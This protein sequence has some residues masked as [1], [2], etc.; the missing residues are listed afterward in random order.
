MA[1]PLI[2]DTGG[3]LRA[4]TR[5]PDGRSAWPTFARAM[6]KAPRVVV[7][8]PV[9]TE[10]DYFL[11]DNRPAMRQLVA[12]LFNPA[13][14]LEYHHATP[15]D[16]LRAMQLDQKFHELEIGLV[17]GVVAAIAERLRIYAVLTID[18]Q[19]FEPLRVGERF[20]QKLEI[21]P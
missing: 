1:G 15:E 21:V 17:D 8:G 7:P 4:I 5:R 18:R 14:T 13:T 12:E 9:L 16:I 11:R 3:L 6:A 20:T 2:A 19:D 10:V